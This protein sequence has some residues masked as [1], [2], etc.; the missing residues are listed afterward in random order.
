[1]ELSDF[2]NVN[3]R[4][5]AFRVL[6]CLGIFREE[7]HLRFG[8]VYKP[9]DYVENT[10]GHSRLEGTMARLRRP[11]TLLE[12]LEDTSAGR[13]TSNILPLGDRFQLARCLAECLYVIH[14]SG[15]VHKK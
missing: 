11:R 3:D 15:W 7:S 4:P 5:S 6:P 2:L 9:P 14:A 13:S 10:E 1:M 12:K 8:F